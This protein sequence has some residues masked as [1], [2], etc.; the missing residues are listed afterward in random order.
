MRTIIGGKEYNLKS[1]ND[2]LLQLTAD[3][4]NNEI[5]KV[6]EKMPNESAITVTVL[7]ALNIAEKHHQSI[8]QNNIDKDFLREELQKMAEKLEQTLKDAS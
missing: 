7:A 3:M 4:V 1:G 6:Q 5:A 2:K 8:E